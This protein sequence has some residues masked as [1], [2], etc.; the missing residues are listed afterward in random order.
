MKFIHKI[1]ALIS[2]L[3]LSSCVL[4]PE[5]QAMRDAKRIRSEQ[6]LQVQL[7]KQCDAVAAELMYEHFN[8][9]LYRTPEAQKAFEHYYVE[10]MSNPV[11]QNCYKLALE[12]Y[13]AQ[14]ELKYRRTIY[15]EDNRLRL[16]IPCYACY[17]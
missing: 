3:T 5:Q 9:P 8:P 13:K 6:Q 15:D 17:L 11:F 7:A 16:T 14:E 4:T 2:V 10:K 1:A 12:N